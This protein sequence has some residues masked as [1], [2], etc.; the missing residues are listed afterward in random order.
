[1]APTAWP[2]WATVT[3]GAADRACMSG[4]LASP[5]SEGTRRSPGA[6]RY[7]GQ[8]AAYRL[9]QKLGPGLL[10]GFTEDADGVLRIITAPQDLRKPCLEHLMQCAEAGDEDAAAVFRDI[11]EKLSAVA[12]EME[13]LLHPAARTRFLFGRFVK[14]PAVFSLLDEGFRRMAGDLRLIPSDENLANTPLMRVLAQSS[15]ATVAQFGQAVGAN[16]FALT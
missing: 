16:Y 6:L 3:P 12:R 15:D 7:M 8:A 1:M 2:N 13:Y 14:R 4:V 5:P 11:G 10:D 9:A